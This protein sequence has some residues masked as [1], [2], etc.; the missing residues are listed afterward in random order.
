MASPTP[1]TIHSLPLTLPNSFIEMLPMGR[2]GEA[3][4]KWFVGYLARKVI[5]AE[6]ERKEA[7]YHNLAA[8]EM[9]RILGASPRRR[10]INPLLTAGVIEV[11]DKYAAGRFSKGYRLS[12]AYRLELI[13]GDYRVEQLTDKAQFRRFSR[14]QG[15]RHEKAL[16]RF[17][18]LQHQLD[19]ADHFT[20][21]LQALDDY[22]C[23]LE[24][25]GVWLGKELTKGRHEY[26]TAQAKSMAAF[27]DGSQRWAHFASGRIHTALTNTPRDLR[28]FIIPK[29][30]DDLIEID[31]KSA[32]LVFLC[33]VIRSFYRQ[34]GIYGSEDFHQKVIEDRFDLFERDGLT[35][36]DVYPFISTVLHDDIYTMFQEEHLQGSYTILNAKQRRL[37][38]DKREAM[39]KATFSKILFTP[40]RTPP[41]EAGGLRQLVWNEYPSVM[42]FIQQ[43]ND[44]STRTKRSSELATLLQ[45]LEGSFFNEHLAG[46]LAAFEPD[47]GFFIIYDAIF[48]SERHAEAT[49][50][51]LE[52]VSRTLYR[53]E[54]SH[55]SS[56]I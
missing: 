30:G 9:E 17:P 24:L 12:T 5:R 20:V 41:S 22:L 47:C 21:D 51:W 3:A 26:L 29:N 43:F 52:S 39:K 37:P 8:K 19:A 28:Q 42:E 15:R 18:H 55:S 34:G 27:F 14:W 49:Q 54:F 4:R 45:E 36:S 10:V 31:L 56:H 7:E 46:A 44:H 53:V 6:T 1:S 23:D 25:C 48:V 40:N 11:N 38:H 33:V 16:E 2:E 50:A 13:G 35:P 32:Q